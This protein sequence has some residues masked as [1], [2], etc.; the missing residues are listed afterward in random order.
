MLFY[1]I[2]GYRG[3]CLQQFLWFVQYLQF[4]LRSCVCSPDDLSYLI[5]LGSFP[6]DHFKCHVRSCSCAFLLERLE[7]MNSICPLGKS[8][9]RIAHAVVCSRNQLALKHGFCKRSL[10]QTPWELFCSINNL[11]AKI[12]VQQF[13]FDSFTST[14]QAQQLQLNRLASTVPVQQSL[15]NSSS[16]TVPVQHSQFNTSS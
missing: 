6:W 8:L 7:R 3:L 10:F 4:F 1:R 2:L 14:V 5:S 11:T 9:N 13:Q 15:F 12:A 16:A